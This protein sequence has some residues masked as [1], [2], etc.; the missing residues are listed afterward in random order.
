MIDT[1]PDELLEIILTYV[2]L[3]Q[4]VR[5]CKLV[6]KKWL[7]AVNSMRFD[8]L[9]VSRCFLYESFWH[10]TY[11]PVNL[12]NLIAFRRTDFWIYPLFRAH[13]GR[14]KFLKHFAYFGSSE[15][16]EIFFENL[17]E[18]QCLEH[19]EFGGNMRPRYHLLLHLPALKT[20]KIRISPHLF[21]VQ[22]QL[23]I[24]ASQLEVLHCY[25]L[26]FIRLLRP[27]SVRT[28]EVFFSRSNL[29][30]QQFENLE[31]LKVIGMQDVEPFEPHDPEQR[32]APALP[33][34][35]RQIYVNDECI[36]TEDLAEER[37]AARYR[38]QVESS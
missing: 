35:L 15:T 18:F 16:S 25:R 34:S 32:F 31:T 38:A 12:K 28:L 22:N 20:L 9:I 8:E 13:F 17:C 29:D 27:G 6:S 7:R 19:L 30:L 5:N 24:D 11:R 36:R 14:L 2:D 23:I 37:N 4:L 21:S 33:A 1:L 26:N 10:H 3:V